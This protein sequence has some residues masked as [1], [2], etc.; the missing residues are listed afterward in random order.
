M[1]FDIIHKPLMYPEPDATGGA[2][3]GS[4]DTADDDNP[5]ASLSFEDVQEPDVVVA[6][7]DDQEEQT[8]EEYSLK[9]EDDLGLE[10]EE[11]SYFTEAAKAHGLSVDVATKMFTD[12]VRK[13]NEH[14]ERT[15]KSAEQK[16]V[17]DLRSKWGKDF[18]KNTGMAMQFIATVGKRC[19]WSQDMM[20]SFRNAGAI[21]VF[22][23][24][25]RATNGRL[26][27]GANAAAATKV[28]MNPTEIRNE[29]ARITSAF[30]DARRAGNYDE[31]RKLSDEHLRLSNVLT[32]GKGVRI[33]T[34]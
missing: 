5:F 11:V 7:T 21:S 33:L 25:A 23:D 22:H 13:A 32:K 18:N 12:I 27:L 9:F 14:N 2:A 20:N 3:T 10:P 16:A 19:G 17:A 31:A 4:T 34:V 24:I 26:S 29:Q 6:E 15:T 28:Q 30:L 1:M 8:D